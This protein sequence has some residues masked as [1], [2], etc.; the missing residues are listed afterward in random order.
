M[1]LLGDPFLTA[2]L[3]SLN[4]AVLLDA[5]FDRVNIAGALNFSDGW[6]NNPLKSS[7]QPW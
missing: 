1:Q 6:V 3:A 7:L 4:T 2:S 5:L